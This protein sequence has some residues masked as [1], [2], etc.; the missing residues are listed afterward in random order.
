M[1]SLSTEV[2]R[3]FI[4]VRLEEERL[5]FGTQDYASQEPD[6]VKPGQTKA[7]LMLNNC[8]NDTF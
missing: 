2:V 6:S 8:E 7:F 1:E 4:R 3:I 5:R